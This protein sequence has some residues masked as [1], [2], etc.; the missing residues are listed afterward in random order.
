MALCSIARTAAEQP[1]LE[2]VD[3]FIQSSLRVFLFIPEVV[4]NRG[5][6]NHKPALQTTRRLSCR[7]WCEETGQGRTHQQ[8]SSESR[9]EN[10]Q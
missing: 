10:K 2:E 4:H 8:Y 7:M 1:H 6:S 3:C 9:V 5:D